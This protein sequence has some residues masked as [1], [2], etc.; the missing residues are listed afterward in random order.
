MKK[1]LLL[2]IICF[3]FN[4]CSSFPKPSSRDDV[5]IIGKFEII[6]T[7]DKEDKTQ[8]YLNDR[9]FIKIENLRNDDWDL[10]N[11]HYDGYFYIL[12]EAN[13]SYQITEFWSY[14]P[15]EIDLNNDGK[16]DELV[17]SSPASFKFSTSNQQ[18]AYIGDIKVAYIQDGFYEQLTNYEVATKKTIKAVIHDVSGVKEFLEEKDPDKLWPLDQIKPLKLYISNGVKIDKLL[19]PM[20]N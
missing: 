16:N 1:L 10:P 14:F 4:S 17:L 3:I 9:I 7:D 6:I 20:N 12:G 2:L 19:Q 11:T 8:R 18:I 15:S 13:T 5:L